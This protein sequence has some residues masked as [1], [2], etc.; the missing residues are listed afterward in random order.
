MSKADDADNYTSSFDN[1]D[2]NSKNESVG[3]SSNDEPL[4]VLNGFGVGSFHQ[5]RLIPQLLSRDPSRT[6]YAVDYLGQGRSWPVDCDD[7]NSPN[8]KDLIYSADTWVDQLVQ[9]IEDVISPAHGN[10]RT[11]HIAGN[12]V[13]GYLSVA[14]ATRRPDLVASLCLMNATPVWGLNLPGW[15]GRLPPPVLPRRIGR[16]LFDRIRDLGTIEKYLEA[17][18]VNRKAFDL[19]LV[20]VAKMRFHGHVSQLVSNCIVLHGINSFGKEI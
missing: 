9:F 13:G 17:A 19:E 8:E 10:A 14:L 11:V 15:S 2:R 5:H 6:I 16:Y 12:S 1:S 18:Y 4:L 20:S 3:R 7:G